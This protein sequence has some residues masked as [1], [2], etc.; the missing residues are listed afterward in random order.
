MSLFK[1]AAL[2]A[3]SSTL[4]FAGTAMADHSNDQANHVKYGLA[5]VAGE[6][7]SDSFGLAFEVKNN[8]VEGSVGATYSRDRLSD[9]DYYDLSASFGL[10]KSLKHN[11]WGSVGLKADYDIEHNITG[12]TPSY[13]YSLYVGLAYEPTPALEIFVTINPFSYESQ[14]GDQDFRVFHNGSVG[15]GYFFNA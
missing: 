7:I 2:V 9:E 1:T 8:I 15:M 3:L 11:V 5:A 12:S 13:G 4:A 14:S 6:G 10:R